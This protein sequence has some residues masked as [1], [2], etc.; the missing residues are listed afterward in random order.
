MATVADKYHLH[1][2]PDAFLFEP[3]TT[4][5]AHL[6]EIERATG[7]FSL[8]TRTTPPP[9]SLL[10]LPLPNPPPPQ[11]GLVR[12]APRRALK[13]SSVS[14]ASSASLLVCVPQS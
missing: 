6:L 10:F 14:S 1:L 8:K 4:E 9:F 5:P 13:R 7:T 11:L 3:V 12:F 2:M